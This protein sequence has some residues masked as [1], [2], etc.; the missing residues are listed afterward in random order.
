[1]NGL[2]WRTLMVLKLAS[3]PS[4]YFAGPSLDKSSPGN[5]DDA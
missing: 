5:R 2:P 1:M 3:I 4:A